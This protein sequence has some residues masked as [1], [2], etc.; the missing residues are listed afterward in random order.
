[1]AKASHCFLQAVV[2]LVSIEKGLLVV[3]R[4]ITIAYSD[5]IIVKYTRVDHLWV[6]LSKHC[7]LIF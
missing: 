1:M 7:V 5:H 4:H 3:K 2:N 6:L